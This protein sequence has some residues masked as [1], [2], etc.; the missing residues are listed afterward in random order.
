LDL[1]SNFLVE[2]G[3]LGQSRAAAVTALLQELN[4]SV[5]GSFIEA[6]PEMLLDE[7]PELLAGFD[8]VI[9]TQV[10]VGRAWQ[11]VTCAGCGRAD[12]CAPLLCVGA[13]RAVAAGCGQRHRLPCIT[14]SEARARVLHVAGQLQ[15]LG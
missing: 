7:Q 10:R 5:A 1:G 14:G 6:A 2:R 12:V 11:Q 8:L 3:R 13:C 15:W 4:D 9:A